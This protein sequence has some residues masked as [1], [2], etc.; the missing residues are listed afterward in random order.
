MADRVVLIGCGGIG[1]QLAAAARPVPLE[2]ARAALAP[3]PRRRRRLRAREPIATGLPDRRSGHEQGRG[4]GPGRRERW[5]RRPGDRRAHV[6]DRQRRARRPRGRHRPPRGRQPPRRGPSSTG[7]SRSLSDATLIS[8][9]NDETDGN[10]Q[11]VRRRDGWS[12]DGHL[13]EIHP[14]IG[15]ADCRG[16]ARRRLPGDGGRAPAAPRDEPDGRQRDAQLPL[17]GQSSAAASPT[18][19]STST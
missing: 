6:D 15:T 7:I 5:A 13:I 14:E 11:L 16:T 9:G 3:R 12:V 8:G 10:V 18:A 1:S 4:P 2:P 17:A 19:R